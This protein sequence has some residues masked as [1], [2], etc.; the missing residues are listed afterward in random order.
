MSTFDTHCACRQHQGQLPNW[1]TFP[2]ALRSP[3]ALHYG[4]CLH[5]CYH[6]SSGG[7]LVPPP[8]LAACSVWHAAE[9]QHLLCRRFLESLVPVKPMT[10]GLIW[11]RRHDMGESSYCSSLGVICKASLL[12]LLAL[13]TCR[14]VE[15][16]YDQ[17]SSA[18]MVLAKLGVCS[19]GA[20]G[21][22]QAL[23]LLWRMKC[24]AAMPQ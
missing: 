1:K 13:H 18:R 15:D 6:S 14:C 10:A 8:H 23:A 24:S 12:P 2:S 17:A 5:F 20:P 21:L 4:D 3:T 9:Q 16:F 7:Q 11:C 22:C 19:A